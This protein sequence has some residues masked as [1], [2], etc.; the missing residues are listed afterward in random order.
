MTIS[1]LTRLTDD[2][3]AIR[4]ACPLNCAQTAPSRPISALREAEET[5]AAAALETPG[6]KRHEW[7]QRAAQ[8][9]ALD[10]EEQQAWADKLRDEAARAKEAADRCGAEV[11]PVE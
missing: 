7:A 10:A 8:V 2:V 11:K 3:L 4:C 6:T 1:V 9:A 5:A